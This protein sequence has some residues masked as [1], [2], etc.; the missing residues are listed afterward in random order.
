MASSSRT[1]HGRAD[2][3]WNGEMERDG[4][5]QRKGLNIKPNFIVHGSD[6]DARTESRLMFDPVQLH[7]T[8]AIL[9]LAHTMRYITLYEC[10]ADAVLCVIIIII[11]IM[12]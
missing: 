3:G 12:N 2:N 11:G 9:S 8:N 10:E 7:T 5:S 1:W 6:G 4:N